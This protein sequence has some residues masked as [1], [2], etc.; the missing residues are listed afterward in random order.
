MIRFSSLSVP[1]LAGA[2]VTTALPAQSHHWSSGHYNQGP[3]L[4]PQMVQS[5]PCKP[6][7]YPYDRSPFNNSAGDGWMQTQLGGSAGCPVGIP[8][9]MQRRQRPTPSALA[10]GPPGSGL[11]NAR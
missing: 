8:G 4:R 3:A 6:A 7:P 10:I 9:G 2:V 1:V 5:Y 11:L